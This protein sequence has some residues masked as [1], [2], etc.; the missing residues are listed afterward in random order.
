MINKDSK[1]SKIKDNGIYTMWVCF[2]LPKDSYGLII[3]FVRKKTSQ[4]ML[5]LIYLSR[6]RLNK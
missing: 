1:Y 2:K 3:S 6:L 4:K 5:C